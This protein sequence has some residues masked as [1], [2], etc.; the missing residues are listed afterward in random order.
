ML[1]LDM[2]SVCVCSEE[3]TTMETKE[4]TMKVLVAGTITFVKSA[5]RNF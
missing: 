1:Q 4:E 5:G 2:I 3:T